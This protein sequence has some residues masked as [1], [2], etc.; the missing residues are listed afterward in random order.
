MKKL[1]Y[2]FPTLL[3]SAALVCC[4]SK[5]A[6]TPSN[7]QPVDPVGPIEPEVVDPAPSLRLTCSQESFLMHLSA[8]GAVYE[9]VSSFTEGETVQLAVTDAEGKKTDLTVTA[10]F[11]GVAYVTTATTGQN[12][13][14][15]AL[16]TLLAE[17]NA[18]KGFGSTSGVLLF[19]A[20]NGIYK[21]SNLDFSGSSEGNAEPMTPTY[22]F[23]KNGRARFTFIKTGNG[24][25][26]NIR[27]LNGT[28]DV[29]ENAEYGSTSEMQINPGVYDVTVNLRN[30]TFQIQPK[31]ESARRITVMGSSVPTG[32]GATDNKGYMYLFAKNALTSGWLLS[33]RSIPGNNTLDLAAR[34]DDL[35]MD[36]GKY[37]IY[38]LSLGNEGI[39][40]AA[41]QQAVY[42]QWKTN[43][44]ALIEQARTDGKTV[45]VTANYGRGDFNDS[46]YEKVKALNLEIQQWD[47]PSVNLLGSVDDEAG[48]WPAGYQNGDDVSHPNDAGHAEMSYTLVPSLFD[49]LEAGKA[50]PTRQTEGNLDLGSRTLHFTPEATVHPFT[51]ACYVKTTSTGTLLTVKTADGQKTVSADKALVG[52]GRLNDGNWHLLAFTHY[53]AK[54]VSVLYVDGVEQSRENERLA[55]Q[56]FTLG[57]EASVK[58]LF[59]WR[60]AM[61][62][63]E[64]QALYDGKMLKSSLELYAPLLSGSL[65]NLAPSTNCSLILRD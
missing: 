11:S 42:N 34:Y 47:V 19:Y 36:G 13:T 9:G 43:M 56:T 7:P 2:L 12:A 8:N 18:V 21:G 52:G 10:P 50:L 51:V 16:P 58:E 46:D 23:S 33:N 60:S 1:L 65:S 63:L 30:F 35:L 20:G 28:R 57:P 44:L 41:D 59:F 24:Y 53:Y 17:G 39:H 61:N 3:L 45:V 37:V 25:K 26:P 38:A 49:A 62:S 4:S 40:G 22:P 48:H 29:L 55:P 64:M 15:L 54:G 32:T 5:E 14:F 6:T 31:H 27:R